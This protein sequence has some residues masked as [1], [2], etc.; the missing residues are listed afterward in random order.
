MHSYITGEAEQGGRRGIYPRSQLSQS[1]YNFLHANCF[2]STCNR[3]GDF[4]GLKPALSITL[5]LTLLSYNHEVQGGKLYKYLLIRILTIANEL[6]LRSV[7]SV[8]DNSTSLTRSLVSSRARA[9]IH[10]ECIITCRKILIT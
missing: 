4:K 2:T 8:Q 1:L 7:I 5:I 6:F 3:N 9:Q 10:L